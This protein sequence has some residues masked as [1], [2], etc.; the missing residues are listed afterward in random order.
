MR[1]QEELTLTGYEMQW[2]VRYFRYM[3]EKWIVPPAPGINSACP[4]G[5]SSGT[6][7]GLSNQFL[8]AGAL[9]YWNRKKD[10]WANLSKN[11]DM[12]F[13]SCNPAYISPL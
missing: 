8:T 10:V 9:A 3:S 7:S 1:W 6:F 12:V 2:T 11:A 13:K 5:T 4:P